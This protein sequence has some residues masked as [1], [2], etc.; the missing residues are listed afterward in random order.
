[1]CSLFD[2]IV[3]G[4]TFREPKMY[5]IG[6]C[7]SH[8]LCALCSQFAYKADHEVDRLLLLY[9]QLDLNEGIRDVN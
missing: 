4:E 7:Y 1:M 9:M 3:Y 5:N 8:S 2:Q 6:K